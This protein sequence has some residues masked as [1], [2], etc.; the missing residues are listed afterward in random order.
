MKLIKCDICGKQYDNDAD[1]KC[2]H[3]EYAQ[4]H[5]GNAEF[6]TWSAIQ[7]SASDDYDD[8]KSGFKTYGEALQHIYKHSCEFCRKEVDEGGFP[9]EHQDKDGK[10]ISENEWCLVVNALG[11][12]CGAE[13]DILPDY[14]NYKFDV[15]YLLSQ[16]LHIGVCYP[17]GQQSHKIQELIAAFS[18][19]DDK[20]NLHK[21]YKDIEKQY[22]SYTEE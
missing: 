5:A 17:S 13:W 22:K 15:E 2:P 3:C 20:T 9:Y 1:E 19:D 8:S 7:M 12:A 4:F 11:T 6:K 10:V 21:L 18:V 14:E 16:I